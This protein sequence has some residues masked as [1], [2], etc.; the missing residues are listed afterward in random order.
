[1]A[2]QLL[3]HLSQSAVLIEQVLALTVDAALKAGVSLDDVARR[4]RLPA[5]VLT[6]AFTVGPDSDEEG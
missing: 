3:D 4:S 6:E 1:M 5:D 2:R